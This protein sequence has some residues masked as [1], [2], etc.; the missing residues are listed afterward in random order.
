MP[1]A[2]T[3]TGLTTNRVPATW[4]LDI[5]RL[6]SRAGR[7]PLTGIDRVELAYLKHFSAGTEP[8]LALCRTQLGA[9]VVD[10][11]GILALMDK[12]DGNAD[13][14]PPDLIGKV[15]MR[16]QP[17]RAGAEAELRKHAVLRC[18]MAALPSRLTKL[19]DAPVVYLNVGHANL[20]E[21]TLTTIRRLPKARIVVMIHDTIPLDFPGFCRPDS[22]DGF[23][24]K[25]EAAAQFADLIL[26]PSKATQGRVQVHLRDLPRRPDV[27]VAHLGIDLAEP[28]DAA[29]PDRPY[30]LCVGTIEPRK[31]HALLLD[32]WEDWVA[33]EGTNTVPALVIAGR[34]G[35]NNQA[36]F[37][38][39]DRF[40]PKQTLIFE[41]NNVSDARLTALYDHAIALAFPSFVEGYGLPPLE[42]ASRGCPVV[43]RDMGVLRETLGDF[44][45]YVTGTNH[46]SWKQ[47]LKELAQGEAGPDKRQQN[48][49]DIP[50]W[51]S[52]FQT[53]LSYLM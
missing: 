38:R 34:R 40:P 33:E 2:G 10:R 4:L 7:G 19:A 3:R 48:G 8:F 47:A 26:C 45:I 11:A 43:A 39:L 24:A 49:H 23:R 15:A 50:S 16:G 36:L 51:D 29:L 5:T 35:W 37:E 42:A 18:A 30:V 44:P 14:G 1:G 31:N 53:L 6:I 21:E 27:A 46:Y 12:F 41:E 52:H 9:V 28:D 22:I 20:T 13:W 32:V 17:G 25:F